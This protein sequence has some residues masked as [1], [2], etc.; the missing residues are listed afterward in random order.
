[1]W[2]ILTSLLAWLVII[3]MLVGTWWWDRE[4]W[5]QYSLP[6]VIFAATLCCLSVILSNLIAY[7]LPIFGTQVKLDFGVFCLFLAGLLLGPFYGVCTAIAADT[8]GIIINIGGVYSAIFTLDKVLYACAGSC[9]WHRQTNKYWPVMTYLWFGIAYGFVSLV[10][11]NVFVALV[12]HLPFWTLIPF[13]LI[14]WP[15]AI[16]IYGTVVNLCFSTC[17]VL[18]QKKQTSIK[19]WYWRWEQ[20]PIQTA[21]RSWR[22]ITASKKKRCK[23]QMVKNSTS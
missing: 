18:A 22:K 5:Q 11:D 14:K 3:G 9:L 13:K 10:L 1:M 23:Q 20:T 8:L 12:Y 19:W 21:W 4:S 6:T 16:L 7:H 2:M 17:Y 15:F